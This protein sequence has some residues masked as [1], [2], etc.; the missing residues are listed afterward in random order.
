MGEVEQPP[1]VWQIR[2]Y[3]EDTDA[4]GV[5]Y[6]SNYLNFF[7]RARTEFLRAKG[8]HQQDLRDKHK[9]IWVVLDMQIRFRKAAK[10]DDELQVTAEPTWVKGVRVG[11]RQRM[12][13]VADGVEVAT[14]ELSVAM[15]HAD[16]L[17]P[18]RMP[19]WLE[20][21]LTNG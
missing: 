15:L 10:L 1:F 8:I 5:V 17:K 4:G 12:T 19:A 11:F 3:Y 14:A 7:E 18:A 16:N 9:L 20:S 2:V 6:H 13:R 21:E